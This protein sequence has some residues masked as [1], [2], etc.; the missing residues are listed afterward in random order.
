[1]AIIVDMG[2]GD[3]LRPNDRRTRGQQTVQNHSFT[4]SSDW[5][6]LLA[7]VTD[8]HTIKEFRFDLG[9]LLLSP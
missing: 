4:K 1:M 6:R 3:I 5:N 2:T 7:R 8:S 9:Q